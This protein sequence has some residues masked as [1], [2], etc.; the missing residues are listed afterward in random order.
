MTLFFIACSFL[1]LLLASTKLMPLGAWWPALAFL[2]IVAV[3]QPARYALSSPGIWFLL[4]CFAFLVQTLVFS[5]NYEAKAIYI[6]FTLIAP[7]LIFTKLKSTK[8]IFTFTSFTA[9][10]IALLGFVM[11]LNGIGFGPVNSV[12]AD[13]LFGTPNTYATFINLFL[14]P[15]LAYYLLGHGKHFVLLGIYI[16]FATLLA[17]QS[18]GGYLGLAGSTVIFL[19]L[20]QFSTLSK[21]RLRIAQ[22]I[23]GCLAIVFLFSLDWPS[24]PSIAHWEGSS[25]LVSTV[26]EGDMPRLE[27]LTIAYQALQ[28]HFPWGTGTFTFKYHVEMFKH[29]SWQ[30]QHTSFVHNDYLQLLIENGLIGFSLF[31]GWILALY[32]F[33]LK[34]KNRLNETHHHP[35]II[36]IIA[37]SS[38]LAH[39]LVDF[40]FYVPVFQ[41]LIG[42]Y[43]GVI[44]KHLIA[45]DAYHLKVP[46]ISHYLPKGITLPFAKNVFICSI[47][48]W[49]GLPFFARLASDFSM[50]WL[51]QLDAQRAVYWQ[52]IARTLQPRSSEYYWREGMIWKDLGVSRKNPSMLEKSET[53]FAKGAEVNPYETINLIHRIAL[54]RDHENLLTTKIQQKEIESWMQRAKQ[55]EPIGIDVQVE[56]IRFLNHYGP[57]EEAIKQAELLLQWKPN[58]KLAKL[59]LEE[60]KKPK[61]TALSSQQP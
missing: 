13:V 56:Y 6:A 8:T 7:F 3:K 12:R 5:P 61:N 23:L 51:S 53:L 49:L 55:L 35:A 57:Q 34:L 39:A 45:L 21:H 29:L 40:P 28:H 2:V 18:R 20:V 27:L 24:N 50:Q 17:A 22:V 47:V 32:F 19:L 46:T 43:L 33:A 37:L 36:S 11:W 48:I 59:L 16:L 1:L 31:L 42:A 38:L 58:A 14:T 44:N 4:F 25:R 60:V 10:V 9:T 52:S 54:H 15:L 30:V 26:T 41:A